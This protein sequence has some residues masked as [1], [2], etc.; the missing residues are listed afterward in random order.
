MFTKIERIDVGGFAFTEQ[1]A[2][3]TRTHKVK[4]DPAVV[5]ET[6]T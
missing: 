5:S 2:E 1:K 4:S 6:S 3:A